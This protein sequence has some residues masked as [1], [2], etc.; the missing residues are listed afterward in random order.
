[1]KKWVLLLTLALSMMSA[2][3]IWL[4]QLSS[5]PLWNYVGP[6]E[7]HSYHIAWWHSIWGPIFVPAG[8]G[9]FGTIS[10]FWFRP[11]AVPRRIVWTAISILFV[12]YVL[13][14]AWWAPLMA[15][16]GASP[17]EFKDVFKWA[18]LLDSLGMRNKTPGQLYQLL[19]VTHWLRVAL[20]SAYAIVIFWM[21]NLAF[22][23]KTRS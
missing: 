4:V 21:T 23:L 9:L 6:H 15:L 14:Y 22:A 2:G 19:M 17:A 11:G 20:F 8:L 1:M 5:Y 18:P 12:A 16:I 10:L 3:Q 13:T 7:F